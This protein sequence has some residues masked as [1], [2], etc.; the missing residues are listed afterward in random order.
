MLSSSFPHLFTPLTHSVHDDWVP[1][2]HTILTLLQ[3]L[4]AFPLHPA[5]LGKD[6][7]CTRNASIATTF[8]TREAGMVSGQ[9]DDVKSVNRQQRMKAGLRHASTNSGGYESFTSGNSSV[10]GRG[11]T[12]KKACGLVTLAESVQSLWL[13]VQEWWRGCV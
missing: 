2:R 13:W 8:W 3:V 5:H 7:V 1:S 6:P 4:A 10:F 12:K 11:G 9:L